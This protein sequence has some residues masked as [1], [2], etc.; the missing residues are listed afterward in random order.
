VLLVI[1]VPLLLYAALPAI[2]L[3]ALI[4]LK[5]HDYLLFY[6][7]QQSKGGLFAAPNPS[8]VPSLP[9]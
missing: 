4:L 3:T 2:Y 9:Y 5:S 7:H 6:L 1:C 8:A